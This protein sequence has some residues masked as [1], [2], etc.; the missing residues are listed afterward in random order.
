MKIKVGISNRHVHLTKEVYEQLF[1]EEIKKDY[2]LHQG[3]EFATCQYVKLKTEKGIFEK[4]RVVGP[5]RDYNQ[6]EI[7]RSDAYL[8][9]LNPPVRRSGDVKNSESVTLIG[10]KGSV[11]LESACILAERHVHLTPDEAK[12][13]GL[14]DKQIVTIEV[15][16]EKSGKMDV[17]VKVSENAYFEV[18]LDRDDA[19]AYGLYNGD[20]VDLIL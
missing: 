16:G 14:K 4:V 9:G 5:L 8:L 19:N 11:F 18:H 1:D 12:K 3:G 15:K 6:V 7:S 17:H 13:L 20:E 10:P 2:D